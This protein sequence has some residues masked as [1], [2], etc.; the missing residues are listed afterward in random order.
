MSVPFAF[1]VVFSYV[2]LAIQVHSSLIHAGSIAGIHIVVFVSW[3]RNALNCPNLNCII[4]SHG[5]PVEST[6]RRILIFIHYV[7]IYFATAA[8]TPREEALPQPFVFQSYEMTGQISRRHEDPAEIR[9][10]ICGT[11]PSHFM[12]ARVPNISNGSRCS[13]PGFICPCRS[14]RGKGDTNSRVRA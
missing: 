3:P 14:N 5:S 9:I 4:N 6:G 12:A 10:R 7:M 13:W 8:L 2:P 1:I 11:F